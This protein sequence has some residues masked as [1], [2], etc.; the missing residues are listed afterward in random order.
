MAARNRRNLSL[1]LADPEVLAAPEPGPGPGGPPQR[2]D[3]RGQCVAEEREQ[4]ET[5]PGQPERLELESPGAPP[6]QREGP[7]TGGLE[8]AERIHQACLLR[9]ARGVDPSLAAR[10]HR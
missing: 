4:R 5:A 1:V 9:P 7:G 6:G 3:R 8:R 2:V 10:T